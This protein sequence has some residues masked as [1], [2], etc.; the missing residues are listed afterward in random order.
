MSLRIS[1]LLAVLMAALHA[2]PANY[3]VSPNGNDS[4]NGTSP[5]TAWKT[6]ARVNQ[7][8]YSFQPGDKVLFER[9]GTWRGELI[10]GSSG[11]AAQPITVGAYGS[12]AL[13]VIK[14]STQVTGW[15]NHQGQI[16]KASVTTG[17]VDQVYIGGSRLTPARYPNTGWLFN[18]QCNGWQVHSAD[19]TQGNGYW[20]GAKMIF[21]TTPHSFDTINITTY[22]N[23]TLNLATQT[24]NLGTNRWGFFMQGKL[25]ELDS[26]GE[27]YWDPQTQVLYLWAPNSGN[28]NNLTVEAAVYKNGINCYWQRAYLKVENIAFRHQRIAGVLNDGANHVTVTGCDFQWLHHGIR[29]SGPYDTYSGNQFRNTYAT[30]ILAIQG[31]TTITDNTL[32]SIAMIDGAGESTW[33]YFGIRSLGQN[34]VIRGNVLDSIGYIGIS[35]ENNALVEKNVVRH[36]L[37][38]L[39]DGGGI[40]FDHANGMIIQD[41]IVSDVLGTITN[42]SPDTLPYNEAISIGIYFGNTDIT[43][44]SVLRNTVYNCPQA[45]IHVD[46]TMV[47]SGIQVKD[48]IL[49]NNGCQ[50]TMSDYSNNTGSGAVPPY[51]VAN[52]NDVYSGN[53]MYCLTKDQLCM[54]QLNLYGATPVD[55][56]TFTN[57]YY[58]NPYNELSI[59]VR[60]LFA[61]WAKVYSLERWQQER[62]ED[63]GSTRSPLRLVAFATLQE[64][65]GN[66]VQNGT[67]TNNVNG[68]TGWPTNAQ[69]SRVTTHLD[70]GAL[71]AYLPD[72]SVYPSFSLRNPDLF[73]LQSQAWYRVRVSLQ[74][75]AQG[76]VVVGIKGQSQISNPYTIWERKVPFSPERRDLE[77]YFQSDRTDQ[78]QVQLINAWTDPMYYLDNVEVTKVNVTAL[79][80]AVRHKIF[81]NDQPGAQ[82]F[83]LPEGCWK[84]VDGNFLEGPITVQPYSSKVAY[85]VDGP[86]CLVVPTGGVKVKMVL[87]GAV[88]PGD[89]LM[90][91]DL[92]TQGLLPATEPYT[93]LGYSVGNAGVSV[94]AALMQTT[95]ANAVVDW[96]VVQLHENNA[97]YTVAARRAALVLRNG[98]VVMPDGNEVISFG[99]TAAGRYISVGHRNHLSVLCTTPATGNSEL[100]DFTRSDLPTFGTEART[101]DGSRMALWPGDANN[102]GVLKYTGNGNDRDA[103]LVVI[104]GAAPTEQVTGYR[105]ADVNLNGRVSYTGP[106]NDREP[107]LLNTGGGN[108][109]AVRYEAM[110]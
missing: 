98:K 6:I 57:N 44:T 81:V 86:D 26:P 110:P 96:V 88:V 4:Q 51:Y 32:R 43:N 5:S 21:R 95:G 50:I 14:G 73:P 82:S 58:F 68:W 80:P 46:H 59:R 71:K 48:N 107:V 108:S 90:R 87:G 77:M 63:A 83:A 60:N 28:P 89:A 9:G 54:Q 41:N 102:D 45:G 85:Q 22:A 93:A 52:Y 92:R 74:S 99:T 2:R 8:T 31:N 109:T 3:Y 100:V 105:L 62:G 15:T 33:G 18:D 84:D 29:S 76:E 11:T 49:F 61:G 35:A 42:G 20:N 30:G 13:P 53:V 67:F 66:L 27:W 10:L 23:G 19:L 36:T 55:F 24:L 78:A 91:D 16:W 39:N 47:T 40:A 69:V 17:R 37:A 94:S 103:V 72:N 75:N 12:G 1:L 97:G 38:T 25:S 7:A 106:D 56:G 104:G 65:S 64:N 70:N 79:D 34:N 101:L